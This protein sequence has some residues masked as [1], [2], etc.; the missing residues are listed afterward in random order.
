MTRDVRT[1]NKYFAA[2]NGYLGFRSYFAEIFDSRYFDRIFVMKGGPGTGKSTFIKKAAN[3]FFDSGCYVEAIY[4]SSDKNSLDGAIIE[5]GGKRVALID[6]TSPHE[7]DAIFPGAIDTIINLGDGFD[8]AELEKQRLKIL[9]LN[10][11]KHNYYRSAYSYLSII[12]NIDRKLRAD[13]ENL[14]DCRK[15][16]DKSKELARASLTPSCSDKRT[17]LTSSFSKDG[18]SSFDTLIDLA[19]NVLAVKGDGLSEYIFMRALKDE[20]DLIGSAYTVAP[21]PFSHDIIEELYFPEADLTVSTNATSA[22]FVDTT[23]VASLIKNVETEE[24]IKIKEKLLSF[25]KLDFALASMNHFELEKIYTSAMNFEKIS[26]LYIKTANKIS[27][28]LRV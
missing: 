27:E 18:Y 11:N 10:K 2:A 19:S 5:N 8:E 17:R 25:A 13:F 16:S 1:P 4:C 20:A 23:P 7:R 12:G 28:I 15:I 3:A 24:L 9:E 26:D 14:S 21:S 22:L 6:A